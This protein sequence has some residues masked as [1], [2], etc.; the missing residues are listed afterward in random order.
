MYGKR[1]GKDCLEHAEE[2]TPHDTHIVRYAC[3]DVRGIVEFET[4]S[5]TL[6]SGLREIPPSGN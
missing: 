3:E 1:D 6:N 4:T 2:L 5:G